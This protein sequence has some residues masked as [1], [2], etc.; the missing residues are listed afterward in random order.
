MPTPAPGINAST[1]REAFEAAQRGDREAAFAR[2]KPD[3]E[4]QMI[5]LRAEDQRI[6]TGR[7]QIWDYVEVLR[8]ELEGLRWEIDDLDEIGDHVV[9]RVRIR[10]R[11]RQTG[12]DLDVEF[13][14]VIR[15][16]EGRIARADNF[17]DHDEAVCDAELRGAG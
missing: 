12:E 8:R 10:G 3:A 11:N 15:I 14:S 16:E 9:A 17:E 6:H 2:I 4:W 13:S 5:G 1:V 7:G